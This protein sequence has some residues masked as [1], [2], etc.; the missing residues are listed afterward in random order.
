MRF[1][2]TCILLLITAIVIPLSAVETIVVGTVYDSRTGQPIENANVYY[3]GTS[4]GC[5]TNEEGVFMVRGDLDRK[6]TLVVSAIGYR[7]QR[8]PID[9]GMSA[10]VQVEMTERN[11]ELED[12]FVTPGANPALPLMERVRAKRDDND[13]TLNE[14]TSYDLKENKSLFISDIQQKH[15]QRALWKSLRRGMLTA[16][17]SSLLLP[18]YNSQFT[19]SVQGRTIRQTGTPVQHS[20]VL[21]DDNYSVLLDGTGSKLNFYRNTISIYG[22]SF[23][24]PLA[25]SGNAHY[26]YWL[27]DSTL[28]EENRKLYVVHFRS[29]N[30]FEPSFN[31]EMTIDSA[32]CAL[33][34]LQASVPQEVSVNY[35]R[36]LQVSQVYGEDNILQ[37]ENFSTLFDFAIKA[38]TSHIFPTVLLQKS[39]QRTDQ[40]FSLQPTTITDSLPQLQHEQI[41]SDAMDSLDQLPVVK[42]AKFAAHIIYTGNV[43]T[44]TCV[45]IGN[46]AEVAKYTRHEGIHVG[47]PLTTNERFSKYVELSG[48]VG[49]GFRDRAAKGKGQVRV[50]LPTERRHLIGTYYWDH[51]VWTDVSVMDHLM[52]ENSVFYGEQ[53]FTHLLFGSLWYNNQTANTATRCREFRLW[54]E[55]DWA[56]GVETQ[57]DFRTGRMGYGSPYVGYFNIPSYRYY[58]LQAGLRLGW[59]ERHVDMFMRR[60]HVHNRYPVVRL[61]AEMGSWQLDG[62]EQQRLYGRLGILVQ[63]TVGLGMLGKLDYMSQAGVVLGKVPYP[64]LE[65]FVGNQSYTYD[66]YRFTLMDSYQ[67][68]ADY[69]IFG[70]FHWNMEGAIFNRIPGIR[71]LHLRELVELK[72][73]YGGLRN[74]HSTVLPL[75][76][77][78]RSMKVPYIE[79]GIGIGNILR[80]ADVYA[81]FRLTNIKDT[82]TPWWGIRA[83]FSLGL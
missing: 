50:K 59:H 67:Y 39:V 81:V 29:K 30:S 11:T 40:P 55:N 72:V 15:L 83:R 22:K 71:Y 82:Q 37:S 66:P 34:F 21:T 75:P 73:A 56:D 44:G 12:V 25:S 10:G 14:K 57:F 46:V 65:H 19:Y 52:R 28:T 24:S 41:M 27:A 18:L 64:L 61:M 7:T 54:T 6:H 53:D 62:M 63:Q 26:R 68:A 58:T 5:A 20:A 42:V 60:Y 4:I 23:I 16:E 51:Y 45:D 70:H 76:E 36:S 8:F 48:Y 47:I 1:L 13:V 79:A 74:D 77:T 2:R 35:L 69:Y 31:G 17:D 43:P 33:R 80:F 9:P 49:Y 78:I 3:R 38:D 32:T